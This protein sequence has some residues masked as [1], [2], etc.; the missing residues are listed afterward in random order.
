M[1]CS[2]TVLEA[3][4]KLIYCSSSRSIFEKKNSQRVD[5]TV[6]TLFQGASKGLE[7]GI[8]LPIHVNCVVVIA[9][10]PF[11]TNKLNNFNILCYYNIKIWRQKEKNCQDFKIVACLNFIFIII[12]I[13]F[14]KKCV[15]H[16]LIVNNS[17]GCKVKCSNRL[18]LIENPGKGTRINTA[19]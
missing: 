2:E 9:L 14:S 6:W 15:T 8:I 1:L 11:K 10:Y 5:V 18:Y 12:D 17:A 19:P 7:G 4:V 3:K 13:F 16:A